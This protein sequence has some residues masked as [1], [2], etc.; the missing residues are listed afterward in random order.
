MNMRTVRVAD[1]RI[2]AGHPLALIAG[3][4]V[5]ESRA[6]CMDLARKLAALAKQEK[7]P[8]IFKASYDK[9]NRSSHTAYRGP[10]ME[11]GLHVLAEIKAKTGLPIL[12]DVHSVA[13]VGPA[14]GSRSR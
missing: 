11:E 10:G 5:I 14:A 8:L 1:I 9:A 13:E 2:G 6:S 4:C 3:P 12:T 7:I